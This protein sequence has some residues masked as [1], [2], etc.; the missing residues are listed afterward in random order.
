VDECKPLPNGRPLPPLF[1][2]S[3]AELRGAS[4]EMV[5]KLGRAV[6]VD[7]FETRVQSAYGFSA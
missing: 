5:A 7:S 1:D 4:P 3:A 2:F 6:Q